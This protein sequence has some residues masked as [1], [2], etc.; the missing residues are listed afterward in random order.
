MSFEGAIEYLNDVLHINPL[1]FR[2]CTFDPEA[3][4]YVE[5]NYK[6]PKQVVVAFIVSLANLGGEMV[7]VLIEKDMHY[8]AYLMTEKNN[9][10][11]KEMKRKDAERK[12]REEARLKRKQEKDAKRLAQLDKENKRKAQQEKRE[13]QRQAQLAKKEARQ[14]SLAFKAVLR[15]LAASKR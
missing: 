12:Q 2:L 10:Q 5:K 15:S 14:D 8:S 1:V 3:L 7:D 6:I 9:R 13:Q 11:V 4:D